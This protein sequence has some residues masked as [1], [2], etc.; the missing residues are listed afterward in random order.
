MTGRRRLTIT[1]ETDEIIIVKHSSVSIRA[2]C[3]VCERESLLVN[4]EQAATVLGL[5]PRAVNERLASGKAH[6]VA[7]Q[8]GQLICLT[9]FLR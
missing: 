8:D 1:I 3:A 6:A 5:T 2:W 4:P 7:V 9:S